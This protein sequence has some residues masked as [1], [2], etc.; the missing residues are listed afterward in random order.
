M[1]LLKS[2]QITSSNTLWMIY[3]DPGTGKTS[4]VRTHPAEHKLVITFDQSHEV[5][6]GAPGV[7]VIVPT[8]E[9]LRN[10]HNILP[11]T[12][13]DAVQQ[14]Y[15][16]IVLD[17]VSNVSE[18][19]LDTL[20]SNYKDN[21]LAYVDLQNWFRQLAQYMKTLPVE[22]LVTAW[23]SQ[24]QEVIGTSTVTRYRPTMN[25]KTRSMFTGLFDFVGRLHIDSDGNRI[26]T[27]APNEYTFSKNRLSD[28]SEFLATELWNQK[29]I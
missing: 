3:G 8:I 28:N 20:K 29:E 11:G 7:D 14:G 16:L 23:E 18:T 4:L 19:I 22:F 17:N 12:L 24:E 6:A 10:M 15:G 5:L 26:I 13:A 9:E 1:Q 21:R 2:N 25:A 27:T